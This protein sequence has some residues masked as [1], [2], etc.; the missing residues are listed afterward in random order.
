MTSLRCA[1]TLADLIKASKGVNLAA[2]L[3]RLIREYE[4]ELL[5]LRRL[6]Q[7]VVDYD[8][9]TLRGRNNN[10]NVAAH[11]HTQAQVLATSEARLDANVQQ[12]Y[13][14]LQVLQPMLEQAVQLERDKKAADAF[15]A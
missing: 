7:E 14:L 6:H 2:T 4:E 3:V 15:L 13:Q 11:Q 12:L 9:R 1:S 5:I 10:D 8:C